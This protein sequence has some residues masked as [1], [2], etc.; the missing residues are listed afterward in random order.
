[1]AA[2]TP[3]NLVEPTA[4]VQS[5][6]GRNPQSLRRKAQGIKEVAF[7]GPVGTHEDSERRQLNIAGCNALVVAQGYACDRPGI[8]LYRMVRLKSHIR[9][10]PALK[11]GASGSRAERGP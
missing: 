5:V 8:S 10:S 6:V 1:M 7:A 11:L 3:A 2:G 4:L 9:K